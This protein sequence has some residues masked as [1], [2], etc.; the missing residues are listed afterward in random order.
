MVLAMTVAIGAAAS[1]ANAQLIAYWPL[2]DL[3]GTTAQEMVYKDDP[4]INLDGRFKGLPMWDSDGG[5]IINGVQSGAIYLHGG[6]DRIEVPQA[7]TDYNPI[8]D[9]VR[10]PFTLACWLRTDGPGWPYRYCHFVG[11]GSSYRLYATGTTSG[12][13][14]RCRYFSTIMNSHVGVNDGEWHHLVGTYDGAR[15]FQFYIDG[16]LDRADTNSYDNG[17]Y[18]TSYW[19]TI[20]ENYAYTGYGAMEGWID[21]VSIWGIVLNPDQIHE[22]ME[23]GAMG[24]NIAPVIDAGPPKISH[25]PEEP[26]LK[27]EIKLDGTVSDQT[28]FG[29]N[30]LAWHW[31]EGS[32][33]GWSDPHGPYGSL[34]FYAADGTTLDNTDLNGVVKTSAAHIYEVALSANDGVL[35]ANEVFLMDVRLWDWTGEIIRYSFEPA[36]PGQPYNPLDPAYLKDTGASSEIPDNLIARRHIGIKEDDDL[37]EFI[38]VSKYMQYEPGIEGMAIH[39]RDVGVDEPDVD[40]LY[41]QPEL[42]GTELQT[43]TSFET[44]LHGFGTWTLEAFI[45]PDPGMVVLSRLIHISQVDYDKGWRTTTVTADDANVDMWYCVIDGDPGAYQWGGNFYQSNGT[46]RG[47]RYAASGRGY[48][49]AWVPPDE[50]HHVGVTADAFY[51]TMW[52]NGHELESEAYDGTIKVDLEQSEDGMRISSIFYDRSYE[53]LLD[54]LAINLEAKDASHFRAQALRLPLALKYP[55]DGFQFASTSSV[56]KWAPGKGPFT[57][58]YEVWIS[59]TGSALAKVTTITDGSTTYAPD[60]LLPDTEYQWQIR[61]IVDAGAETGTDSEVFTFKTMALGFEGMIGHWTFD[62]GSGKIVNDT[63]TGLNRKGVDWNYAGTIIGDGGPDFVDGWMSADRQYAGNFSGEGGELANYVAIKEPNVLAEVGAPD[64]IAG[65]ENSDPCLFRELPFDSFTLALWM[66]TPVGFQE[67]DETFL[68]FGNSYN[69]RRYWYSDYAT[70][71]NGDVGNLD[72]G[73]YVVGDGNWH[74]IA[75][76]Y[77]KMNQ[78]VMLYVDGQLDSIEEYDFDFADSVRDPT[79]I[80][81]NAN[82]ELRIAGNYRYTLRNFHGSIDDVRIYHHLA[83]TASEIQALYD[84][85]YTHKQP[86]VDAGDDQ[87]ISG[88]STALA[89]TMNNDNLPPADV[90]VTVAWTQVSGPSTATITPANNVNTTVSNLVAGIYTFRLTAYDNA[91]DPFDEV[92][93]WVQAVA[94]DAQQLLYYRFEADL[95]S[96]P[97]ILEVDNE[98][99]FGNNY[100]AIP[101]QYVLDNGDLEDANYVA[102]LDPNVPVTPIPL[103]LET[104]NF[105]VGKALDTIRMEGSAE[106]YPEL[107]FAENITVEF[108]TEIANEADINLLSFLGS[109]NIDTDHTKGSGFRFWNP[110]A[111]RLEY[112]IEGDGPGRT[113]RIR[114]RTTANL[115]DYITSGGGYGVF[116]VYVVQGWKHLAWT[117]EKSTGISR[118]F[119]NGIPVYITHATEQQVGGRPTESRPGE[120]YFDGPDGR[121]LVMPPM[122]DLDGDPEVMV[123][124][125][126]VDDDGLTTPRIGGENGAN[127]DEV[128]ISAKVLPPSEFLIVGENHCLGV[129]PADIDGNCQVDL[130][131]YVI[132]ALNWMK[133][134]DPYK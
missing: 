20:G 37:A 31:E 125:N 16:V 19:F 47:F 10:Q 98:M 3:S 1:T 89:G 131:D 106:I 15:D 56:L 100:V 25:L 84:M 63:A 2:D 29:A 127:F 112:Y 123:F 28:V 114:I 65:N 33:I 73:Q 51:I 60:F 105:S 45:K 113:E 116:D 68:S 24:V 70:F 91:Y 44:A 97:A 85:G 88:V 61:Q 120:Y 59:E 75:G 62:E 32:Y 57:F 103:T 69:L 52:C 54:E 129:L 81:R 95:H 101:A 53:G 49:E 39:L 108:F 110:R 96:D 132:L 14:F 109:E 74:H 64:Y 87:V 58:D 34:L 6:G 26:W 79:Y 133:N 90:G 40:W 128:R 35:E 78:A 121:G 126:D 99:A 119:E 18:D 71:G 134:T 124:M 9:F 7:D 13:R 22:L 115:S 118:I 104:N 17:P 92:K 30:V 76:V 4:T 94:D 12:C 38:Y 23:K 36:L 8:L 41:N 102:L 80:D 122:V 83:L 93:V 130:Y 48:D 72:G 43:E 50:W 46:L 55:E 67:I 77:D 117:Y 5:R 21:D 86:A 66:K 42:T 27:A 11:K 107:Q 111:V 82:S